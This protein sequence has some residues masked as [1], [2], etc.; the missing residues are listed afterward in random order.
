MMTPKLGQDELYAEAAAAHG[1]ALARLARAYERDEEKRRDLE[2]DIHLALWKSF[3]GFDGRCSLRTWVYR[4]AHNV[5]ASHAA[6]EQR[7]RVG[8]ADLSAADAVAAHDNPEEDAA[9][10]QLLDRLMVL[11]RGLEPLD[12]Q[13]MILYLEDIDAAETADILGLS[14]GAVAT[15]IHRLKALLAERFNAGG[16]P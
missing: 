6:G 11:I 4:V 8:K 16:A 3:A 10:K 9:Q 15:R 14:P 13:I 2:Q 1:A 12:R 5:A 7:R